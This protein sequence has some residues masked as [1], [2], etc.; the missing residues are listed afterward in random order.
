MSRVQKKENCRQPAL[1]QTKTLGPQD[2][3]IAAHALSQNL[4]LVTH[5]NDFEKVE[6]LKTEDWTS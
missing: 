4:V 6:N 5:D 1:Q 2:L 3:F